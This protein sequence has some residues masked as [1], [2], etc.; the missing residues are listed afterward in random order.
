MSRLRPHLGFGL[1]VWGT[2][3]KVLNVHWNNEVEIE[4]VS[5]KR[6]DWEQEIL[7]AAEVHSAPTP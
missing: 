4:I 2:D 6:G 5:F 7:N 3:S 1:D